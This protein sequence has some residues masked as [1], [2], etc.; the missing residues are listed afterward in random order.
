MTVSV[1]L[2]FEDESEFERELRG[3]IEAVAM[4]DDDDLEN[5]EYAET[6][7]DVGE[8]AVLAMDNQVLGWFFNGDRIH[9]PADT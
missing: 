2:H 1:T 9:A 7:Q 3:V 4:A 8:Q 5:G 6:M